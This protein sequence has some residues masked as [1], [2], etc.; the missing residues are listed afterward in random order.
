MKLS[1]IK[2]KQTLDVVADLIV[3]VSNIAMDDDMRRLL[4]RS[5]VPDG[6]TK[7][8]A[9]ANRLKSIAP[10]L[11]KAH[12]DDVIDILATVNMAD[13]DE[14]ERNLNLVTLMGDFIE[15]VNDEDF[16]GFFSSAMTG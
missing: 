11:I 2:G 7:T 10:G 16:L 13:R 12:K 6:M 5:K 1:E 3:P 8:E 14:Y 9:A 4:E 15:L